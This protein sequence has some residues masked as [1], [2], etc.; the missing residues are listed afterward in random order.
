MLRE[1][2]KV[3]HTPSVMLTR[4]CMSDAC[5]SCCWSDAQSTTW[6]EPPDRLIVEIQ[7]SKQYYGNDDYTMILAV[8]IS[9]VNEQW[10]ARR[11]NGVLH[12]RKALHG[13][14]RAVLNGI[15]RSACGDINHRVGCYRFCAA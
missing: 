2:F 1:A 13:I 11:G 6:D 10:M 9:K 4:S 3:L 14:T 5:C 8:S 12:A 7:H 15:I